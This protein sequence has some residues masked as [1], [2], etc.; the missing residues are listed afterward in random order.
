M[1]TTRL[2]TYIQGSDLPDTAIRWE[3]S[4]GTLINYSTGYTFE[5]KVGTP[6]DA[7]LLTKSTG[8]TGASTD[9]NVTLAWATSGELNTLAVGIYSAQLKATR[10]VDSKQRYLPFEIRIDPAI[11]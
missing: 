2:V 7:A 6:G 11:S 8:I 5:L 1:A 10:G 4:T 9:P 3:D